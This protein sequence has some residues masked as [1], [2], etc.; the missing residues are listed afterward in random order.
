[1]EIGR[2]LSHCPGLLN[3]NLSENEIDDEGAKAIGRALSSCLLLEYV[4]LS[5]NGIGDEGVRAI[6]RALS[7]CPGLKVLQL[8]GNEIGDGG[9]VAIAQGLSNCPLLKELHLSHNHIG[10]EGARAIA[11]DVIKG[12]LTLEV[13]DIGNNPGVGDDCLPHLLDAIKGH[14][15]MCQVRVWDTG[16]TDGGRKRLEDY[17]GSLHTKKAKVMTVLLAAKRFSRVGSNSGF[18][19]LDVD[20][21]RK[22]GEMCYD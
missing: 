13:I 1:V 11:Q 10:D 2:A 3:L 12:S 7:H 20:L 19:L 21:L 8:G 4:D 9:A 18:R 22:L 6:A 14:R 17:L 16:I 15:T 5:S